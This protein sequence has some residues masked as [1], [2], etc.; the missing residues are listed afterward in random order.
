VE[1]RVVVIMGARNP[2]DPAFAEEVSDTWTGSEVP[3]GIWT[4]KSLAYTPTA[5][6]AGKKLA[7]V[8]NNGSINGWDHYVDRVCLTISP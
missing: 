2:A 4:P 1:G 8:F 3:A 7:I 6:G 5:T